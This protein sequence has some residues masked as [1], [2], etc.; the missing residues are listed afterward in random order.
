MGQITSAHDLVL[1]S[2]NDGIARISINRAEKRN[3]LSL[4]TV[5]QLLLQLSAAERDSSVR[6]VILTGVG[7]KAFAAGA[8][9]DELPEVFAN[10]ETAQ[11][12]DDKVT[13]LYRAMESSRLPIIARM[14][15]SAIGGGCLL[16]LA[17]DLRIASSHIKLG[18]PVANI[19]LMLSPH[20]YQLILD[21]LSLSQSKRLL[22]TGQR[23]T[24][25]EAAA[26]GLVD[27][28]ASREDLDNVVDGLARTIVCGAPLAIAASKRI[29]NAIQRRLGLEQAISQGYR[30]VYPS[31]DLTE[32]LKAI[33]EK[34][35]PTFSGK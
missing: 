19:G 4:S 33:R 32:G 13:C 21:Q 24:S 12:Y 8:D 26:I 3:A 28:V 25:H 30:T 6:V 31:S 27:E 17:C 5:S 18:F 10:A 15:G 23:L 20:E 35:T 34:R 16:A 11:E 22:F 29:S 14:A 7:E 2:S 1:L 9:F